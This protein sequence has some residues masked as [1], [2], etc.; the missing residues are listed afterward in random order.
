VKSTNFLS[1]LDV[2]GHNWE[3]YD[4]GTGLY[5]GIFDAGG[6]K[7]KHK[8]VLDV[9]VSRHIVFHSIDLLHWKGGTVFPHQLC[10]DIADIENIV[11]AAVVLS[12]VLDPQRLQH[13]HHARYSLLAFHHNVEV[14]LD[15]DICAQ[16]GPNSQLFLPCLVF[17]TIGEVPVAAGHEGVVV[18]PDV[19]QL[20]EPSLQIYEHLLDLP[21]VLHHLLSYPCELCAKP[22]QNG[23]E[24]RLDVLVK[25]VQDFP[26]WR[27]HDYNRKFY[28]FRTGLYLFVLDAGGFEVEHEQ[29]LNLSG[30]ML[31]LH[32]YF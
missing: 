16:E 30:V 20:A 28:D 31:V 10:A 26:S 5:F 18:L 25:F 2:H 19:G 13:L 27:V 3:L 17:K 8:Q 23:I 7:I 12:L 1:L 14:F 15:V 22:A 9:R 24:A 29:V 21:T 11:N 4:F 32:I 6:F